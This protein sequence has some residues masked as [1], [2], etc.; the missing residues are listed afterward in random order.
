MKLPG[1]PAWM[2]DI[3]WRCTIC[4]SSEPCDCR[5][6]LTCACGASTT[7]ER[8][9]EAEGFDEIECQCPKCREPKP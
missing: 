1:G 7:V 4:N 8:F 3:D 9:P 5:V 2:A 6:R